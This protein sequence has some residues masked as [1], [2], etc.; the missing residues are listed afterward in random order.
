MTVNYTQW[1]R[2][3]EKEA[4]R[5][6]KKCD[7]IILKSATQWLEI[8]KARTPIGHPWEWVHPPTKKYVPGALRQSWNLR[9]EGNSIFIENLQP[10]AHRV[11]YGW[12]KQAP[13][14]MLRRSIPDF[15][16]LIKHNSKSK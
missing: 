7:A 13:E 5:I 8:V 2:N 4:Y 15:T 3:F 14:G 10:Y 6:S 16:A 12:S 1:R 9:I 11:E